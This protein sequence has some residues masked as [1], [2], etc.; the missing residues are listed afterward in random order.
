MV[1]SVPRNSRELGFELL[2]EALRAADEPHAGQAVAPLV[3]SGLGGGGYRRMLR[4]AQIVVG[5]QVQHRLAVGHANGRALRRD[6][7]ALVLVRAGRANAGQLRFQ[8]F[9]EF[10]RHCDYAL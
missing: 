4:Q 8:M 3:D 10:R 6:D 7:D 9:F 5:A 2:V 1:S